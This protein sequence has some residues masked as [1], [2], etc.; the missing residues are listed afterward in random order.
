MKKIIILAATV[1]AG[2]TVLLTGCKDDNTFDTV[3]MDIADVTVQ[4]FSDQDEQ[5]IALKIDTENRLS[6]QLSELEK[7]NSAEVNIA[8][9]GLSV[10]AVLN[11]SGELSGE[12]TDG[13]VRLITI[14]LDGIAEENI[15]ITD[16]NGNIIYSV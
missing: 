3:V 14:T 12:E 4:N 1:L 7:V 11:I 13:A 10:S 9:D 5:D 2:G 8:A 16:Q 15:L 6:A